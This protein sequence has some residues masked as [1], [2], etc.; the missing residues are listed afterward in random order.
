MCLAILK[1]LEY[2]LNSIKCHVLLVLFL[3]PKEISKE[4]PD[5][6]FNLLLN[7]H[8]ILFQWDLK[9]LAQLVSHLRVF[10]EVRL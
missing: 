1:A 5:R 2:I 4:E 8:W 6:I 9:L 10:V 7:K 3:L